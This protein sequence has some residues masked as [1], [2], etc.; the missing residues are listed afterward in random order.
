M[1]HGFIQAT[2]RDLFKISLLRPAGLHNLCRSWRVSL[3]LHASVG[4]VFR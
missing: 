3:T 4:V 2:H 1:K